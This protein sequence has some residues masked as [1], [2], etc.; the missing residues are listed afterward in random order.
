MLLIVISPLTTAITLTG[1]IDF[2]PSL[3]NS[4][5]RHFSVSTGIEQITV[6]SNH[7]NFNAGGKDIVTL[8]ASDHSSDY[9]YFNYDTSGKK[10]YINITHTNGEVVVSGTS[11]LSDS[12]LRLYEVNKNGLL[13]DAY[14]SNPS[15]TLSG[16]GE[17]VIKAKSSLDELGNYTYNYDTTTHETERV[18]WN[19]TIP[20]TIAEQFY[21]VHLTNSYN[22]EYL[23]TYTD[24]GDNRI[25]TA[26][27]NIPTDMTTDINMSNWWRFRKYIGGSIESE[28]FNT[29]VTYIDIEDIVTPGVCPSSGYSTDLYSL[30]INEDSAGNILT[31]LPLN[32]TNA[33]YEI[34]YWYG[35]DGGQNY[36]QENY[37]MDSLY[38]SLNDKFYNLWCS[39]G[40]D[41][42]SDYYYDVYAKFTSPK[43]TPIITQYQEC[44][45]S[46]CTI[47][48]EVSYVY[49]Q[50][51]FTQRLYL[52]DWNLREDNFIT[53]LI[54]DTK[55]FNEREIVLVDSVTLNKLENVYV[56]MERYFNDEG[57]W[58][59]VQTDK[60]DS[61]G[62]TT[63]YVRD[64]DTDYRFTFSDSEGNS[65][66][67]TPILKFNCLSSLCSTTFY[68]DPSS[69][70][71]T[72]RPNINIQTEFNN[73]TGII[74]TRWSIDNS[75]TMT[76]TT[77]VIKH[78][79]TGNLI[80][81]TD[82]TTDTSDI[83]YCDA[84]AHRGI[85]DVVVTSEW[86]DITKT[87]SFK[88]F[89]LRNN[90]L[91]TTLNFEDSIFWAFGIVLTITLAAL[92]SPVA[93]LMA[94]MFGLIFVF[95]LG[96]VNGIT[97]TFIVLAGIVATVISLKVKQ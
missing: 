8:T 85:I 66:Q 9:I 40:T 83:H 12:T 75:R 97:I 63:F 95:M 31:Y 90:K 15:Y 23:T 96:M 27:F 29:S 30:Y 37:N 53:Y 26:E 67:T 60:T 59:T 14:L 35:E 72:E 79:N 62:K 50:E 58:V 7:I 77:E 61:N 13:L 87:E 44:V 64:L 86:N 74:E 24:I 16:V 70:D 84:T 45:D 39:R 55:D 11:A 51:N 18:S 52:F 36:I 92:F 57:E 1:E 65:Y 69:V 32:I 34:R 4:T 38:D 41:Y 56:S 5:F 88:T 94:M 20:K 43:A 6:E 47:I 89:D 49:D 28:R 71:G 54:N 76:V 91:H 25:Y 81:C 68:T 10:L 17:Y 78:T 21:E 80:L 22:Y 19:I 2:V 3:A 42:P 93:S 46:N 48:S 33:E 73:N 82:T